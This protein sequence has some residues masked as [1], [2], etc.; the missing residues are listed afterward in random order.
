VINSRDVSAVVATRARIVLWMA[1]GRRRKDVAVLSGVSP[2]TV[3]R[4][5]RRYG[6]NGLA[7]LEDESHAA[8]REQ[9]PARVRARIL[10]LSRSTPPVE[11]GL[12][13]WSSREMVAYLKRVEGVTVSW[14]YVA[15]LWRDNNLQP[16][17]QGTFKLSR[18]PRFAEKVADIV[19]LYLDPPGGAVVL[20]ID[21]KTQIQ[22]LDRSQPLLPMDFGVT[23]Q[24]THD[25]KRHGITNLFA[26][27]DVATGQVTADCQPV[28]DGTQFLAFLRKA[29]KPHAGKEIHVV[30]DNLSTHSTPDV[31][32]WLEANPNVTFHFTPTG[33][34]W[35]NMIE[36]WFGIITR[37]SIRRGTF[38]SVNALIVRIRDYVTHWNIDAK[39][40]TWTATTNEILT[41]VRWVQT[42]VRQLVDNNAK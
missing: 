4:W 42:S 2:P 40:F 19:G 6:G 38:T 25:Y 18:D 41:K 33:S 35:L 5:V 7:G 30:L 10:A 39:P 31:K 29:V 11:T 26:A 13:H 28:R 34:S 23:E 36:I 8:P 24:R 21:E 37:Q 9:V 15:K 12:S 32:A 14:H 17:R 1:E 20:S 22:A 3:D 27:L 16:H